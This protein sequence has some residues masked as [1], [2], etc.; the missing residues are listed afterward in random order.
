MQ[1]QMSFWKE[2]AFEHD[3]VESTAISSLILGSALSPKIRN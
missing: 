3:E 1:N 2:I